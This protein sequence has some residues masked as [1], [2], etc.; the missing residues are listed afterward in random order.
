[1][2]VV[3]ADD[4][5]PVAHDLRRLAGWEGRALARGAVAVLLAADPTEAIREVPLDTLAAHDGDGPIGHLSLLRW[6]RTLPT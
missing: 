2:V 4:A 5:G 6:L 3:A 1:M